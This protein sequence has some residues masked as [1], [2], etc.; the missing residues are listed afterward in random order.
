MLVAT[1]G[2]STGWHGKTI[3]LEGEILVL[4]DHG[5]VEPGAVVAYDLQGHLQWASRGLRQLV[6]ELAADR[7]PSVAPGAG[8]GHAAVEGTAAS[9]GADSAAV[10][11]AT[12]DASATPVTLAVAT[13][14]EASIRA[15]SVIAHRDGVF[16]LDGATE[17]TASEVMEF[18]RRGQISWASQGTRAWVGSKALASAGGGAATG[19]AG[20]KHDGQSGSVVEA[21]ASSA[22][23][24]GK[25]SSEA[26]LTSQTATLLAEAST[27]V[28]QCEYVASIDVLW[29]L[30]AIARGG[31]P[32][33]AQ[34]VIDL[35]TRIVGAAGSGCESECSELI[36]RS[37]EALAP[38]SADSIEAGSGWEPAV[39]RARQ[40]RYGSWLGRYSAT[41]VDE[42]LVLAAIGWALPWSASPAFLAPILLASWLV[43]AVLIEA[44]WGRTLGKHIVGMEVLATDDAPVGIG[45]S[46]VRNLFKLGALAFSLVG[47]FVA[48]VSILSSEH[49]QRVGDRVAHTVVLYTAPKAASIRDTSGR[50]WR[51]ALRVL[52]ITVLV[53]GLT[54]A[55]M[56][57]MAAGVLRNSSASELSAS[58]SAY[59]ADLDSNRT[60]VDDATGAVLGLAEKSQWSDNDLAVFKANGKVLMTQR[61]MWEQR[62][63]P[64]GRMDE[65]HGLWVQTL[66]DWDDALSG[67]ILASEINDKSMASVAVAD[68]QDGWAE[69]G[70]F[71]AAL[72][73][74]KAELAQP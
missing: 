58:E 59:L 14:R 64:S 55:A 44:L 53:A 7:P 28:A 73:A 24:L 63:S 49:S 66:T 60:A 38:Q 16:L 37:R 70:R 57:S 23:A 43:Y 33:A 31:D 36:A 50:R 48:L 68:W 17:L 9:S 45:A 61:K 71:E 30:D 65:V 51:G 74:L 67:L 25:D 5:P 8:S 12:D 13:F 6:Y 39:T 10:E 2:P 32:E 22:D 3:T 56:A 1:F 35:A 46:L 54:L 18:D 19:A 4:E 11:D 62:G 41:L 34:G 15:G 40:R 27:L 29:R 26:E 20:T 69:Y 21:A 52:A 47:F 42:L 72:Q